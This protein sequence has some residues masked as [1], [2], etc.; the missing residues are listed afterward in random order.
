MDPIK[1]E[2]ARRELA[3]RDFRTF[4]QF[5]MGDAY[6]ECEFTRELCRI[7][8]K[9]V[10]DVEA[11]LGPQV[12][13]TCPPRH[14][15]SQHVTRMLPAWFLGRNPKKEFIS[16]T[17]SQTLADLNGGDV[18]E[19]L[20]SSSYK[21][22][23]NVEVDRS[24]NSKDFVKLVGGKNSFTSTSI[25][26]GLPGRGADIMCIDDF[27]K[28]TEDADSQ[29]IRDK[30]RGWWSGTASNRIMAGGGTLITATRWH[31]DDLIGTLLNGDTAQQWTVYEFPAVID[32]AAKLALH[33]ILVPWDTLMQRKAN[34]L[35]RH[36][37]AL[38]LCK[39]YIEAG[40]F[41]TLDILKYYDDEAPTA[42]ALFKKLNWMLS[43]DYATSTKNS[44]DHTCVVAAGVSHDRD[45]YIH[46]GIIYARLDPHKAVEQTVSYGR[47]LKTY[48][49]AH[50]K[51]VIANTLEPL[52]QIEQHKQQHYFA[53]E[54][55]SRT[56][57]KHEV[58]NAIK[59]LMQAG[60]VHL[61]RSKR[62]IIEPLLLRFMPDSDGEDDL[63]DALAG[64]G[65]TMGKLVRPPPPELPSL[66]SAETP[67]QFNSR[68]FR[69]K[70]DEQK[71]EREGNHDEPDDW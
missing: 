5:V 32:E 17:H 30:I 34:A 24:F 22:L 60:K 46:P 36:W 15:K 65:I 70:L 58:A 1:R 25:E 48:V 18:R 40:A 61:P 31:V 38:Y 20:N 42:A 12:I 44:A 8:Q 3:R 35:P 64:V 69:E 16:V 43:A 45:I 68:M 19:V 37:A 54:R 71:R 27:H 26:A 53:T 11:G 2:L 52:F 66:P 6:L 13:L 9:F 39:P 57:G 67:L 49:L 55:Y 10:A 29:T 56:N 47:K 7:V 59:G 41:F 23:F 14:G 4:V 62:A 63:I 50:E 28:N 51:G 33:P 21:D